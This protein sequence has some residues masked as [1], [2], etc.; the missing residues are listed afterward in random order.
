MGTQRKS[1][2]RMIIAFCVCIALL[3]PMFVIQRYRDSKISKD[4]IILHGVIIE[5]DS[6]VKRDLINYEYKYNGKVYREDNICTNGTYK[7]TTD[8]LLVL[9]EKNN[10]S[11]NDLL[12]T[13]GD[14]AY[15]DIKPEDTIGLNC[16]KDS[17]L[18]MWVGYPPR[19]NKMEIENPKSK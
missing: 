2:R 18:M 10:P 11:N 5:I 6:G 14:F 4:H 8:R 1:I 12:E 9:V 15:Y 19:I 3:L 16:S 17:I 13:Y 7:N